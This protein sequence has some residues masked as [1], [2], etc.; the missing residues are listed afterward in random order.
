MR[1]GGNI[2]DVRS[3]LVKPGKE[4]ELLHWKIF[5]SFTNGYWFLDSSLILDT[6][7]LNSLTT[8]L[9]THFYIGVNAWLLILVTSDFLLGLLE[10]LLDYLT[11]YFP[12]LFMFMT[13]CNI[14]AYLN[15][16]FCLQA[17]CMIGATFGPRESSVAARSERTSLGRDSFL[18]LDTYTR[19]ITFGKDTWA[20]LDL[21]WTSECFKKWIPNVEM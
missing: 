13:Y 19:S 9:L 6:P 3:Y 5:T 7:S 18:K 4:F 20:L 16:G 1:Q 15:Y 21:N 12:W 11:K 8:R 10:L 2:Y 14:F 17:A